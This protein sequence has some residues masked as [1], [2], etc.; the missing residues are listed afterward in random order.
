[1]RWMLGLLLF[2]WLLLS[3]GAPRLCGQVPQPQPPKDD[4]SS[5]QGYVPPSASQSVQIGN[6]YL[7]RKHLKAALSRY[8]EAVKSD[9]HYAPA[10]EGLGRVYERIGLPQKALVAYRKYLDELP[11]EKDARE[12]KPA[13]KA[14]ARLQRQLSSGRAAASTRS[15]QP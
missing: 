14:I 4:A 3:M 15:A 5:R 2:S 12:A 11:S 9:P 8:Q 6:F 13:H 10:Y 1:M 7:R